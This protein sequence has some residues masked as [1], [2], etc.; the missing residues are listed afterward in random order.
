LASSFT[1]SLK[2]AQ[3]CNIWEEIEDERVHENFDAGVIFTLNGFSAAAH[4]PYNAKKKRKFRELLALIFL[5]SYEC[6]EKNYNIS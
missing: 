3:I 5:F 6:S 4:K 2:N 1:Q